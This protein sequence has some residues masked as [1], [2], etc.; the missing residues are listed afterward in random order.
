MEELRKDG[1]CFVC[2]SEN[3]RGLK[4]RVR[5]WEKGATFEF[6]ADG[7]FRGWNKYLH[8]GVISL[9]FDE[10]LGWTSR[11]FGYKA[12]TARLEVRYRRPVPVGSR[13]TFRG[14]LEGER[15]GVLFIRTLALFED[16]TVAA[17]GKGT[18]MV[19]GREDSP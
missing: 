17:E 16:G 9:L 12:L 15:K 13:L 18:M 11:Y 10:L 2:G 19:V 3:P 4:I 6:E 5:R 7:V 1:T 8:G 14:E